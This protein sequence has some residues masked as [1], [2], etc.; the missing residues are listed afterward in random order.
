MFVKAALLIQAEGLKENKCPYGQSLSLLRSCQSLVSWQMYILGVLASLIRMLTEF[1][2]KHL[3]CSEIGHLLEQFNSRT[4]VSYSADDGAIPSLSFKCRVSLTVKQE[5]SNFQL[6][7]R[8]P[9][10]AP[11]LFL[12]S[13]FHP[14]DSGIFLRRVNNNRRQWNNVYKIK[15]KR[16]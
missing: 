2:Q 16:K 1:L 13:W 9:H 4:A 5:I 15:V 12:N 7:F 6:W 14:T 3:N 11:F 8:L 10:S